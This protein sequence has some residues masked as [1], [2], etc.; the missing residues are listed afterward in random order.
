MSSGGMLAHEGQIDLVA[1]ERGAGRELE[2]VVARIAG[3]LDQR[4]RKMQR[5]LAVALEL[6]MAKRG[7]LA[8]PDLR[9][10]VPLKATDAE[11]GEAFDQR[12]RAARLGDHD[13]PRDG[14]GRLA[15]AVELDEMDRLVE[16]DAGADAEGGATGHQSGVERNDSIVLARIDLSESGLEP[17][18]RVLERLAERD[19]LDA[20]RLQARDVGEVCPEIAFDHDQAIGREAGDLAAKRAGK[21]GLAHGDAFGLQ[22]RI[23][24]GQPGAQVGIFPG[25]DAAMRQAEPAIGLD[26]LA[27]ASPTR[28]GRARRE[29]PSP[30]A[31]NMSR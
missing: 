3:K 7:L 5:I 27:S 21:V 4:G 10:G 9:H 1:G 19:H 17:G 8:D 12:G 22:Q 16:E 2:G 20:G 29:A 15:L 26:G 31:S 24:V 13:V 28:R 30:A 25:L 14:R 18:R 23:D 6:H 11:A